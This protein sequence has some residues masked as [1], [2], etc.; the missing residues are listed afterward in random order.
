MRARLVL[1]I[2]STLL[3]EA[4]LVAI[5]LWALPRIDIRIPLPGLI[6]LMVAWGAYSVT[7]YRIGSRALRKKV[8]INLPDMVGSK[9]KVVS[10]LAP[11]GM[12]RIKGELWVA[13][14]AGGE[15][16]PGG[17]VIVVGQDSLKLMVREVSP[18]NDLERAE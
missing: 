2:I 11:E 18:K 13:K 8:V 4:A 3:E 6:A 12:V 5:V 16:E 14:S 7:V 17:E 15:I 1:A 9:G 10:P